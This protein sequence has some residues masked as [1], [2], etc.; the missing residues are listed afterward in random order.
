MSVIPFM[1]ILYALVAGNLIAKAIVKATQGKRGTSLAVTAS[2]GV[3]ASLLPA[4][5][6]SASSILA[7]SLFIPLLLFYGALTIVGIWN[8]LR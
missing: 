7:G 8:W 5:A 6:L 3:A 1:A 2:A 4:I